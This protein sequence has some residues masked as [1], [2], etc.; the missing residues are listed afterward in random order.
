MSLKYDI[1]A[2]GQH[3]PAVQVRLFDF[4]AIEIE[5]IPF[6]GDVASMEAPIFALSKNVDKS[7]WEWLSA[8]RKKSVTVIPSALYGRATIYDKD[9]LIYALSCIVARFNKGKPLSK[10]VRFSAHGY[11]NATLKTACGKNYTRLE[12]ALN[13]LATTS[14]LTNITTGGVEVKSIF[15]LVENASYYKLDGITQGVEITLSDWLFS[16]ANAREILTI[17]KEYFE[18]KKPIEKRLYEIARKHY[19]RQVLWKIG[20]SNLKQKTGSRTTE[21]EFKRMVKEVIEADKIPDYRM[22]LDGNSTI[23]YTRDTKKLAKKMSGGCG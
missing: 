22:S 12:N 13:R 9:V 10:T 4:Y 7:V 1:A 8:D 2:S 3:A 15:H 17:N 23:F 21:I 14:I 6:K 18:L 5:D 20:L 11:F 16:A 19:G